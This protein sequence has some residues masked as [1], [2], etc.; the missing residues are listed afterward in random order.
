M[1]KLS[2]V[3]L[4]IV[5]I[6]FLLPSCNGAAEKKSEA[7]ASKT[8]NTSKEKSETSKQE[9]E[10]LP[11]ESIIYK[12]E[13]VDRSYKNE[14]GHTLIQHTYNLVSLDGTTPEIRNINADLEKNMET[15]FL[16]QSDLAKHALYSFP[17]TLDHPFFYT[18]FAEVTHNSN[19]FFCVKFQTDWMMGGVHNMDFHSST[20]NLNTG[21]RTTIVELTGR[22]AQSL[23]TQ[24]KEISW[25]YLTTNLSDELFDTAY[26]TLNK[27]K[28]EEFEFYL[29]NSEIILTFPTYT[30]ASGAAGPAVIPTGIYILN[31]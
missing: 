31:D 9:T 28:L 23:E 26:N 27:Y 15:F 12:I 24:L 21:L 29:E 2:S 8:I 18:C 6:C 22:N 1:K 14:Q 5:L 20:Y 4:P 13:L 19:G 11:L 7:N 17:P 3:F 30:F 16:S 10:K 25:H